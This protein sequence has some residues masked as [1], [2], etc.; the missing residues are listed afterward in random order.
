[1]YIIGCP[2]LENHPININSKYCFNCLGGGAVVE[3]N[4]NMQSDDN[5]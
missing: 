5:R 2:I 3:E 1:M 4:L